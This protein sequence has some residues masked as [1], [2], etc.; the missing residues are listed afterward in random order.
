[1]RELMKKWLLLAIV[2]TLLSGCSWRSVMKWIDSMEW[3]RDDEIIRVVD[4]FVK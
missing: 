3:E 2:V 1:L 4:I